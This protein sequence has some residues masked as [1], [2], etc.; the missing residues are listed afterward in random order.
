MD[1]QY[2]A[3][4]MVK[5]TTSILAAIELLQGGIKSAFCNMD[6]NDREQITEIRLRNG[7]RVS[8]CMGKNNLFLDE[9]GKILNEPDYAITAYETDIEYAFKTAFSYSLHSYSKELAMGYVTT[10]G[11]NRVGVCGTAVVGSSFKDVETIKYVSSVNIRIARQVR[12][13]ADKIYDECFCGCDTYK[14]PSILIIGPPA[15]G[16][17]T[18]LRDL[19]RLLGTRSRISL[20]DSQNEISSTF[21]NHPENDVGELTDIFVGY[22]KHSGISSAVRIMSP[23]AIIVDEIGTRDELDAL[24]LAFHSGVSLITAVH[25]KSYSDALNKSSVRALADMAD[26]E[27]AVELTGGYNYRIKKIV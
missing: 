1:R 5:M 23:N 18:L 16:K 25:G 12:G 14:I 11:G 6:K 20:I 3:E 4:R 19:S 26:F 24:E 2:T 17:T 9:S 13:F 7:R 8:I 15:S 27:Y 22:P 10:R 21:K